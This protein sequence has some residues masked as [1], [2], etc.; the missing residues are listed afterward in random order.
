MLFC[1]STSAC[2][3]LK[4]STIAYSSATLNTINPILKDLNLASICNFANRVLSFCDNVIV[5]KMFHI[6]ACVSQCWRESC[7]RKS[8]NW[9]KR[10]RRLKEAT[11]THYWVRCWSILICTYIKLY[12]V[13]KGSDF[14][15]F[16]CLRLQF[17]RSSHCKIRSGIWNRQYQE[18]EKLAFNW[19]REFWVNCW[20]LNYKNCLY[21][22]R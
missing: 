14:T 6:W 3:Y 19:T 16:F 12:K 17:F 5:K 11:L 15:S 9:M 2:K 13:V 8:M 1:C 20:M 18:E 21:T 4:F 22:S 7:K 10:H